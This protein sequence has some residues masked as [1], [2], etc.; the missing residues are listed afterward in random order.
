V[1]SERSVARRYIFLTMLPAALLKKTNLTCD[2]QASRLARAV[3]NR[4]RGV[5]VTSGVAHGV[6]VSHKAKRE[7]Y[8]V[9]AILLQLRALSEI[10]SL[11]VFD[12][13]H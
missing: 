13:H 1:M 10:P 2:A 7:V 9:L 4:R 12:F 8:V 5:P 11:M 6:G 3:V